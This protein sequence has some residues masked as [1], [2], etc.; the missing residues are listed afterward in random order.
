[1]GRINWWQPRRNPLGKGEGRI[2]RTA[3]EA[4]RTVMARIE[5]VLNASIL[6]VPTL[7]ATARIAKVL[8]ALIP[9][10]IRPTKTIPMAIVLMAIAPEAI[11]QTE[12][13]LIVIIQTATASRILRS[14]ARHAN[15]D[16]S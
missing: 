9:I 5:T 1:M 16:L 10:E 11:A 15:V 4:I 14:G 12:M 6:V 2:T 7:V 8:S 3:A 13:I